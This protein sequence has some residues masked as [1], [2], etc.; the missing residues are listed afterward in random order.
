MCTIRMVQIQLREV[1][2]TVDHAGCTGPTGQKWATSVDRTRS[3]VELSA[4]ENLDH[5]LPD[6]L[7]EV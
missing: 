1:V 7:S 5:D 6:D 4:S 3:G 2:V